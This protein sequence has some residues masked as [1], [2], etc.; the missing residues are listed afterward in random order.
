MIKFK[1]NPNSKNRKI[2]IFSLTWWFTWLSF[3]CNLIIPK[4]CFP[5]NYRYWFVR[6]QQMSSIVEIHFL[7][8]NNLLIVLWIGFWT[9]ESWDHFLNL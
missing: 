6:F 2:S 1:C 8:L 7:C 9:L 4:A 5:S 3:N